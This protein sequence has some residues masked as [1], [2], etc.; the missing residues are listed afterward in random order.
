MKHKIIFL[1]LLLSSIS[2]V[3]AINEKDV[4]IDTKEIV[5]PISNEEETTVYLKSKDTAWT[6]VKQDYLERYI[7]YE[8]VYINDNYYRVDW[9]WNDEFVRR[10]LS[11]C[12]VIGENV[13]Q[14]ECLANTT[15]DLMAENHEIKQIKEL[16]HES[17]DFNVSHTC[18]ELPDEGRINCKKRI[19]R[20]FVNNSKFK[21]IDFSRTFFPEK[22]L[23]EL[24]SD[25]D[26]LK[27]N[28]MPKKVLK[29]NADIGGSLNPF[30]LNNGTFYIELKDGFFN[31]NGLT[32]KLGLDSTIA[33]FNNSKNAENLS[34]SGNQNITRYIQLPKYAD[35]TNAM[36]DLRGYPFINFTYT[37]NTNS[38][39]MTDGCKG[40][41]SF[42]PTTTY[43]L[44]VCL[45]NG[46]GEDITVSCKIY[47]NGT[48]GSSNKLASELFD[49]SLLKNGQQFRLKF[50]WKRIKYLT[51][52]NSALNGFNDSGTSATTSL[53]WF[54]QNNNDR[55]E[56]TFYFT[57][58]SSTCDVAGN[59]ANTGSLGWNW[60]YIQSNV[61]QAPISGLCHCTSSGGDE[62]YDSHFLFAPFTTSHRIYEGYNID[63]GV[64]SATMS[65]CRSISSYC[66]GGGYTGCNGNCGC[67]T[68]KYVASG[69]TN[70]T[71][72]TL[73]S[74]LCTYA[75]DNID[76]SAYFTYTDSLI[77]TST[78]TTN[79]LISFGIV[80]WINQFATNS[81]LQIGTPDSISKWN[82]TGPFN[83]SETT[84]N[85]SSTLN[86]A[87]NNGVCDCNG[88]SLNGEYCI[89]PLIFHSDTAGVIEY[90]NINVNYEAKPKNP[91]MYVNGTQ[92]WSYSGIF[93]G[94][95]TIEQFGDEINTTLSNCTPYNDSCNVSLTFSS[96][97]MGVL[98]L[99]LLNIQY[100]DYDKEPPTIYGI[101]VKPNPAQRSSIV[102]I[103]VNATDNVNISLVTAKLETSEKNLTYN[104]TTKLYESTLTTPST[105]G[106]YN[107]TVTVTDSSNIST[108]SIF[109]TGTS[110]S[111]CTGFCIQSGSGATGKDLTLT[112]KDIVSNASNPVENDSILINATIYNFGNTSTSSFSVELKIDGVSKG[113]NSLS[114]S[115]FGNNSTQFNWNATAGNHTVTIVAD[116]ANAIS[117][118]NETNNEASTNI[119]IQDITPPSILNLITQ[120]GSLILKINI[121]DNVNISSV[122]AQVN[123]TAIQLAFNSTSGLWESSSSAIGPGSYPAVISVID[124][125]G[126]TTTAKSTIIVY[127]DPI[128]ILLPKGSIM[129]S[130]ST[131]SD[132]E[133]TTIKINAF[134]YGINQ[135][136]NFV[137]DLLIDGVLQENKTMS[138]PGN[139]N[140][141]TAFTWIAKYGNHTVTAKIDSNNSISEINESNNELNVTVS[142]Q[143]N[144]VP[145][146]NTVILPE[147]TY[148]NF[149]ITIKVNA[150][151]NVNVSKVNATIGTTTIMLSYNQ[152]SHLYE[153]STTIPAAGLSNLTVKASNPNHLLSSAEKLLE[154]YGTVADLMIDLGS[155]KISP[156]NIT[157]GNNLTI[158]ATVENRGGTDANNFKV[159]LLI[160]GISQKNSTLSI[161]KASTLVVNFNWTSTYGNHNITIRLDRDSAITESNESNNEYNRTT[162]VADITPPTTIQNVAS[163]PSTW[164]NQSSISIS[165]SAA[166][167][168]NG[169]YKYEYQLDYGTWVS[170]GSSTNFSLSS[171]PDGAHMIYVKA[172]DVP[173]NIGNAS[174]VTIY[175]DKTAPNTPI[176]K[177]WHSGIN[178]TQHDT[179]YLSWTD[180]E[181]QGSGITRFAISVDNGAESD[182]GYVLNYHSSQLS[183]G[184]HSF[185]IKSYDAS[186]QSS[187]WSNAIT[188][189]IDTSLPASP[190]SLVSTTHP[191][192][193][194]WYKENNVLFNW[195]VPTDDSGIYGY[196]YAIDRVNDTVPDSVSLWISN[197]TIN[198]SEV[199]APQ[200]AANGSAEINV[201][202]LVDGLWYFHIISRDNAGNVGTNTSHYTVKI[203]TKAPLV[204]NF[205]PA[206][207]SLIESRT[208]TFRVDY[209]DGGA[210]VNISAVK[211]IIDGTIV[212]ATINETTLI[213]IP[214]SNLSIGVNT[215]ILNITDNATNTNT[216]SWQFTIINL[217]SSNIN[218]NNLSML[219]ENSTLKIF[220]FKI[221]N[222]GSTTLSSINWTLN[223]SLD[224]ILANNLVALQPNKDVIVFTN[225]NYTQSG[226]YAVNA[227]ARNGTL[228]DSEIIFVNVPS[229]LVGIDVYNLNV[230]NSTGTKRIF[231][232]NVNTTLNTNLTNVSWTFD[233]KNSNI[234]NN[235]IISLIQPNKPLFVY[236][237]YNFTTTGAFNV[238]ATA[239][240]NT[241]SDSENLTIVI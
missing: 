109:T 57:T 95:V 138:V 121:S 120:R 108:T 232:F 64:S 227:T 39:N 126:L 85:F 29:G 4:K 66:N 77:S 152:T 35:V 195:S 98:E 72:P 207:N 178:W 129:F 94:P 127:P 60:V 104:E 142:V 154:I 225:Y 224:L 21:I 14:E 67:I 118:D 96:D 70:G 196:Y 115:A 114:V 159:E 174:N 230:L 5:I 241:V 54:C 106:N 186:N 202:G 110:G 220:E 40:E 71:A 149:P 88:C 6:I 20:E 31:S 55:G 34:F 162:F 124:L 76:Y 69:C 128:D 203:D 61:C 136:P 231:E 140:S 82:F 18:L 239:R 151:D 116:S 175:V 86:S 208:P 113:T 122:S 172:V 144:Q 99:S 188:V 217:T 59:W 47:N 84:L 3:I 205:T 36:I 165:W 158:N 213:Y 135:T 171:Q 117:E 161:S 235:T 132:G 176:I 26:F 134:N 125:S 181:D 184:S 234:I 177:E 182:L 148:E 189:Y 27:L 226:S 48:F 167:D 221:N 32:I 8:F 201:S 222:T 28:D 24:E 52:D 163:S 147:I 180:P 240:N 9:K 200:I 87:L 25:V 218:V 214:T 38:F 81:Y 10:V 141:T 119:Y 173:G 223:T 143:D 101:F 130:P 197:T 150:T 23:I 74:N 153:N 46:S 80:S 30:S 137:V 212:N 160:G 146:I 194:K 105:A 19:A 166:S 211:L 198:I 123:G 190:A 185:K 215:A 145:T 237:D 89:I 170:I 139:S 44:Q 206:N 68:P 93:A 229:L 63:E 13:K 41:I 210:G 133:N 51:M 112:S 216:L 191:N 233:T 193:S 65:T 7:D 155:I 22:T 45:Q 79:K 168:T 75:G 43:N 103:S 49:K 11:N 53:R 90:S 50:Y 58:N 102:N 100:R 209:I 219:Y 37:P 56:S 157:E 83:I 97:S 238:N 42:A 12:I 1:A 78:N 192:S 111:G 169:I 33:V 17:F 156:E 183:T 92:V 131:P 228:Q 62:C 2:L 204:T 15:A 164:T 16:K 179:P 73:I 199:I 236:L 107:I 187:N 91:A